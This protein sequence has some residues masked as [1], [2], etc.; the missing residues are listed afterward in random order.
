MAAPEFGQ[1]LVGAASGT[2]SATRSG[3][4]LS[5]CTTSGAT[6]LSSCGASGT[7]T[8]GVSAACA[9]TFNSAASLGSSHFRVCLKGATTTGGGAGGECAEACCCD[10]VFPVS[11]S[12]SP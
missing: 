11:H 2:S 10:K 3:L 7:S 9:A 1:T 4:S 8:L 12:V 5:S 6:C